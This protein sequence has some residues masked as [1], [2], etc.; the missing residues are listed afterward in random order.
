MS[1][2]DLNLKGKVSISKAIAYLEEITQA[3]KSG[4][5]CVQNGDENVVALKPEPVVDLHLDVASKSGKESI[6]LELSW[7]KQGTAMEELPL[8][9]SSQEPQPVVTTSDSEDH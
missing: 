4:T 2:K 6:T 3:L 7:R 5:V 8:R 1:K 9:I